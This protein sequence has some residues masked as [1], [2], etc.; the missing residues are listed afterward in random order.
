MSKQA[1][2][3]DI[4]GSKTEIDCLGKRRRFAN[5]DFKSFENLLDY[6]LEGDK[7]ITKKI[8]FLAL[9]VAGVVNDG[10]CQMTN[11]KWTIDLDK[12]R[13]KYFPWIKPEA[14]LLLNDL[15]AAAWSVLE[16][17]QNLP[18]ENFLMIS[19]GTGLGA[20]F[21]YYDSLSEDWL[22]VPSEAGHILRDSASWEDCLS[23]A[24]LLEIYRSVEGKS[25]DNSLDDSHKLYEL[26]AKKDPVALVALESYFSQLGKFAQI[27]ALTS[28]PRAGI[29]LTGG[30]ISNFFPFADEKILRDSFTNNKKM[31]D[32]L[33]EI[34][35]YF[36]NDS[37]PVRGLEILS[38][39][40]SKG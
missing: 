3:I 25:I 10:L 17:R 32:L 33:Q 19:A 22:I 14:S 37:A 40:L 6:W 39:T 29:Y 4:G 2:L 18:K 28:L 7:A 8:S 1:L 30:I 20:A 24:G 21:G 23:G 9:A 5:K 26:A 27:L 16:K 31:G 15:E 12:I 34:P 36:T 11:L 13:K 38:S 35:L